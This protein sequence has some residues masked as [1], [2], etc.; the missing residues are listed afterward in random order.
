MFSLLLSFW[1]AP[2]PCSCQKNDAGI[3]WLLLCVV[4]ALNSWAILKQG[5]YFRCKDQAFASFLEAMLK[6]F[7]DYFHW[8]EWEQNEME[9]THTKTQTFLKR[10]LKKRE[11]Y[12]LICMWVQT[13][14][15]KPQLQLVFVCFILYDYP[16]C[17][18]CGGRSWQTTASLCV[19]YSLWLSTFCICVPDVEEDLG[20]PQL[21]LGFMCFLVDQKTNEHFVVSM[22]G[23]ITQKSAK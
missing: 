7:L 18:R 6:L 12:T 2:G 8:N 11:E 9:K 19:L 13:G 1:A 10:W 16:P 23:N 17:L 20:K 21:Q 22:F 4:S 3:L 14:L 5:L 15:G